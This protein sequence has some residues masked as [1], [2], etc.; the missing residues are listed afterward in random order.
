MESVE[1]EIDAFTLPSLRLGETSTGLDRVLTE[2]DPEPDSVI[3]PK[4]VRRRKASV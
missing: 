2:T 1:S 4:P 3:A